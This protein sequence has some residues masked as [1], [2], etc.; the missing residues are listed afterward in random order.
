MA[1]LYKLD[2]ESETGRCWVHRRG[3]I[4]VPEGHEFA[5]VDAEPASPSELARILRKAIAGVRTS[6]VQDAPKLFRGVQWR[7]F[8]EPSK[9][10]S[11]ISMKLS[12]IASSFTSADEARKRATESH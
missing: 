6:P 11:T 12:S 9:I 2:K 3:S 8:E 7:G 10:F 4:G 5:P 1:L